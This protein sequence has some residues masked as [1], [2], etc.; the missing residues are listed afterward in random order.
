MWHRQIQRPPTSRFRAIRPAGWIRQVHLGRVPKHLEHLLR[1]VLF[2][3]VQG[4]VKRLCHSEEGLIAFDDVPCRVDA[5]VAKQWDHAGQDL[6]DTT[7]HRGGV[8]VLESEVTDTV[9]KQ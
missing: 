3:S 9:G 6:G 1:E 5:E 8:D 2:T 4:V 7:A